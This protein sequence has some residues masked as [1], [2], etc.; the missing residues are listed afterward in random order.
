VVVPVYGLCSE[1][2][3][4][5]DGGWR[6]IGKLLLLGSCGLYLRLWNESRNVDG[7]SEQ[8]FG[9]YAVGSLCSSLIRTVTNQ[10]CRYSPN[11]PTFR[12]SRGH[13]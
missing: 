4:V 8:S 7:R 6:Q 10:L 5:Q 11:F 12:R 1:G 3:T 2:I 9:A 13:N